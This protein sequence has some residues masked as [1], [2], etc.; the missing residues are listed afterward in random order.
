[1]N[2]QIASH[3]SRRPTIS[4]AGRWIVVVLTLVGLAVVA[5]NAVG[6]RPASE[7]GPVVEHTTPAAGS[8]RLIKYGQDIPTPRQVARAADQYDALPFDGIVMATDESADVFSPRRVD[9]A[10]LLAQVS[11]LPADLRMRDNWVRITLHDELDWSDDALWRTVAAN[12][13]AV[14]R[15]LHE[16]GRPYVGIWFD[17]EWYGEGPSPW[18]YG[19]T[20]R[21]WTPSD[22][23]GAT[24]GL[25]PQEATA[26]ASSRGAQV[27]AAITDGWPDLDVMVLFGPWVSEPSTSQALHEAG[28]PYNDVS[29]AHE[30]AGPFFEGMVGQRGQARVVDGGEYYDARSR[31]DYAAFSDWQRRGFVLAGGSSVP[32]SAAKAHQRAVPAALAVYDRDQ[33]NNYRVHDAATLGELTRDALDEAADYVWL[34]T[35]EHEWGAS[36]SGKPDVPRE[37]V[38]AVAAARGP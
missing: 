14:A 13:G 22:A 30:L 3:Q 2:G 26:L 20:T 11:A 24:P 33:L 19:T 6:R 34:Y 28:L 25:S 31:T 15:A 35:E 12:A 37:Y 27:M 32:A 1:M 7:V 21:A 8:P 38:E 23:D 10:E 36:D 16:S 9:H 29:W 4:M 17:N 18:D 5:L